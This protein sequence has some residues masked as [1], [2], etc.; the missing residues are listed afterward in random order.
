M[1]FVSRV[2]VSVNSL[3]LSRLLRV[4]CPRYARPLIRAFTCLSKFKFGP[5]NDLFGPL[6]DRFELLNDLLVLQLNF[7]VL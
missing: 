7:L 5:I 3:D 2:N 6:I 1:D 4:P